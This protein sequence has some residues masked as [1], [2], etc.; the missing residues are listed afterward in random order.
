M[1]SSLHHRTGVRALNT[2]GKRAVAS[3]G[4]SLIGS[5]LAV[6]LIEADNEAVIVDEFSFGKEGSIGAVLVSPVGS[7]HPGCLLV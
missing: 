1:S 4:T 7:G 5:H 3:F 2:T 6:P